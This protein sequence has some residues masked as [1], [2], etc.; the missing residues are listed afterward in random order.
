MQLW[1]A[2]RRQTMSVGS[3]KVVI[4]LVV[5]YVSGRA[6]KAWPRFFHTESGRVLSAM[7][8]ALIGFLSR[9]WGEWDCHRAISRWWCWQCE[10]SSASFF[11]LCR[12]HSTPHV[13]SQSLLGV[14]WHKHKISTK[15]RTVCLTILAIDQ[16]AKLVYKIWQLLWTPLSELFNDVIYGLRV[17]VRPSTAPSNNVTA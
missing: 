1:S 12:W 16:L 14:R 2:M 13:D 8:L 10:T 15:H 17:V 11:S 7:P 6:R 5:D 3:C 4:R 9:T